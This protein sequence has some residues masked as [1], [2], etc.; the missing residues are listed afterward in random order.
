MQHIEPRR[1]ATATF[2]SDMREPSKN[3]D[4]DLSTP[5]GRLKWA[6]ARAGYA[7]AAKFADAHGI[8]E[9]TY[10]AHES[11]VNGI[12]AKVAQRYGPLL[13]ISWSWLLSGVGSPDDQDA[14]FD[15]TAMKDAIAGVVGALKREKIELAPGALAD[16]VLFV[17]DDLIQRGGGS[18]EQAQTRS[19]SLVTA[20]ASNIIRVA[21]GL[22]KRDPS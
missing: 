11:G 8:T 5:H 13:N 1:A 7:S 2:R 18:E 12:R 14:V 4:E 22:R 6:R 17:Y 21:R 10:R 9:V 16:L 15:R 3:P 19:P 20:M